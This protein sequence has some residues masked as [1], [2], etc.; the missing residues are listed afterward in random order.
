M[1][2]F[3]TSELLSEHKVPHAFF[4][5]EGGVSSNGFTS[6]NCNKLSKDS[7]KNIE[8]NI[9]IA[10]SA[11]GF[12]TDQLYQLKQIHSDV[13]HEA[14]Q[15]QSKK[16][17]ALYTDD[18]NKLLSVYTADCVPILL[19]ARDINFVA[20]IHAGWRGALTG[21]IQSVIYKLI[22]KGSTP[23]NMIAAIGPCIRQ[24]SYEFGQDTIDLFLQKDRSNQK[25]FNGFKADIPS[26]CKHQLISL[27][28]RSIDDLQI[29]TYTESSHFFSYRRYSH[30]NHP[31]HKGYGC[32]L[33]AIALPKGNI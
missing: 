2:P 23:I 1:I 17:D 28:I 20:A 15:G 32:Q 22:K 18:Q 6:L 7:K 31:T 11:L 3:L 5:R 19:Y 33:S 8:Q 27:G 26:Y 16:G 9:A 13:A 29:D 24:E 21:I 25:F 30:E 4:T 10:T 14:E 12:T